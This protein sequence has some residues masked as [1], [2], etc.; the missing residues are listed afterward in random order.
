[1]LIHPDTSQK[2]VEFLILRW[3]NAIGPAALER[4]YMSSCKY[5]ADN[6]QTA[7]QIPLPIISRPCRQIE[8]IKLYI[9]EIIPE[10]SFINYE[11]ESPAPLSPLDFVE[12]FTADHFQCI[13]KVMSISKKIQIT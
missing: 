10:A 3:K 1:M 6:N 9:T 5:A 12:V 11:Y 7:P 13:E 4:I 8:I 2:L